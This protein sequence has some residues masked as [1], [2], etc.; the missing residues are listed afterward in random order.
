MSAP[1]RGAQWLLAGRMR[2]DG[3]CGMIAGR[4]RCVGSRGAPQGKAEGCRALKIQQNEARRCLNETVVRSLP[5]LVLVTASALTVCGCEQLGVLVLGKEIDAGVIRD[6]AGKESWYEFLP[7]QYPGF[8]L[9]TTC[10]MI[11]SSP[12]MN[13][14]YWSGY[15]SDNPDEIMMEAR[16][17][18][19][20]IYPGYVW[21]GK[22]IG[23]T[24]PEDLKS[25]LVHDALYHA[26]ASGA[27]F[28]RAEADEA[29]RRCRRQQGLPHANFE[30]RIIRLF[31]WWSSR[32]H[33]KRSMVVRIVTPESP[34]SGPFD[35][36]FSA[37]V[38]SGF[39]P[40][41]RGSAGH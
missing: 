26:L 23:T 27:D 12:Q 25:T 1:R 40:S 6:A 20:V 8:C 3:K 22:T 41:V 35:G 18:T 10:V 37:P 30:Y 4:Q 33:G 16:G 14:G 17:N 39:A 28:A 34:W 36:K 13:L 29:Y 38:E 9:R 24:T 7:E 19:L 21:D 2:N 15:D 11:C 5:Q 31:G 32:P